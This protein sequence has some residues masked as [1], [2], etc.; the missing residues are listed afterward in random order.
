MNPSVTSVTNGPRQSNFELLRIVAMFMVLVVHADFLAC[1]AVVA[2]DFHACWPGALTRVW[3]EAMSI[4]CVNVFVM[5]SGWFGIRASLKGF[6]NFVFQCLFLTLIPYA[7]MMICCIE[8]LGFMNLASCFALTQSSLWFVKAYIG[9]Y[10][11]APLINAFI[12][13]AD[14]RRLEIF[15]IAFYLFQTLY[16]WHNAAQFIDLGYSTFSFIGLYVLAAYLR[17]FRQNITARQGWLLY[18]SGV[19]ANTLLYFVE[20]VSGYNLGTFVY[21]NPL[22]VLSGV[23]L[24]MAFSR[25]RMRGNRF[26][27]WVAASAFAVYLLHL[28]PVSGMDPYLDLVR[29]VSNWAGYGW[30][31]PA[32]FAALVGVFMASV[33]IDQPRRWLWGMISRRIWPQR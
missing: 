33:L 18:F 1:G 13:T 29:H 8:Q 6:A 10:I 5:I 2:D 31:V 32:I 11:L 3:I 21:V 22:V 14:K 4:V 30:C 9:L 12:D 7:V 15:L 23:G 16:G 24:F 27:N 25:L 28:H 19:S 17:R 20:T 26:I